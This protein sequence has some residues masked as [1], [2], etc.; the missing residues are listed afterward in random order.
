AGPQGALGAGVTLMFGLGGC[1]GGSVSPP[2][3]P[4]FTLSASPANPSIGQG[5]TGTSTVTV[6]GQNGFSDRV[7]LSVTG[8]PAGV[9]ASFNPASTTNTSLL[10]LSV[11]SSVT[12]GSVALTVTGTAGSL[13]PKTPLNLTVA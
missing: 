9:T 7:N 4:S 10:T 2:P 12:T 5:G 6:H 13:S 1:G 11:D 8:I 3:P